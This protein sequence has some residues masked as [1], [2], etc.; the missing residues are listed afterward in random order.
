MTSMSFNYMLQLSN[1]NNIVTTLGKNNQQRYN[2]DK[3][4]INDQIRARELRLIDEN[5][6]N[7]RVLSFTEALEK[8][9][10]AGL[11][12][13]EVSPDAK[14]P[15]AKITDYGKWKYEQAKRAKLI[16]AKSNT[17]ETKEV[18][19]KIGTSDHDVELK[20]RRA[21]EWLADGDRVKVELYL[22]G[23]T[24]YTMTEE[25]FHGKLER[26]L[27][28]LTVNYKIA[29]SVRKSPKGYYLI[30]ERDGKKT[31]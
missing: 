8:A 24:K 25:F 4:Y 29:E 23:R 5:G 16:K 7:V 12:L 9:R 22:R 15:V 19:V 20:A 30:I 21:S 26:V 13:I 1:T 10:A 18:Q 14:P 17:T 6:D 2:K 3:V 28:L 11:D 27:K 31:K